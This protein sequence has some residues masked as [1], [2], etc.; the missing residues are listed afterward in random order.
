MNHISAG[1]LDVAYLESGPADGAPVILLHGFP[2]DVHGYDEASAQL[3]A[4]GF[5]CIAPYLRGFGSTRFRSDGTFRSG[6]QAAL[7]SDLKALMDALGI[8]TAV[9]AGYDWGGRAAC[10]VAA[11]WPERVSGL[12]TC[13]T[14][15]KP[16]EQPHGHDADLAGGGAA[17]LV[18]VLSELRTRRGGA[19]R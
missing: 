4:S 13:G 16:A 18:L 11:L 8:R 3:A 7:G 17:P 19:D 1:A 14:A 10:V 12:V 5:R 15:Y 6:Q 9:L 2:Y